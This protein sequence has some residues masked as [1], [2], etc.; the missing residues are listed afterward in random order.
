VTV[1]PK[2]S[3][4]FIERVES[5]ETARTEQKH[6]LNWRLGAVGMVLLVAFIITV[7]ISLQNPF[8]PIYFAWLLAYASLGYEKWPRRVIHDE[9]VAEIAKMESLIER[10]KADILAKGGTMTGATGGMV[11][12]GDY[13]TE[14]LRQTSI[15]RVLTVNGIR[16]STHRLLHNAG[17]K[18][19]L[20]LKNNRHIEGVPGPQMTALQNWI[21]EVEA[22]AAAEYRKT[23]GAARGTPTEVNRLRHEMAEFERH[24]AL[25]RR[26]LEMFPDTSLT[27]YLRKLTGQD[28]SATASPTSSP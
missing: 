1:A 5:A 28:D 17:L 3:Y 10:R 9:L 16:T 27:T 13:I 26:E 24:A 4:T 25:L 7:S 19:A 15:N 23:V 20:D 22:E 12:V 18:N 8:L 11:S 14:R 2:D 6:L 21:G